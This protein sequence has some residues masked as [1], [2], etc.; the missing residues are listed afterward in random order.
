MFDDQAKN[1]LAQLLSAPT[2]ELNKALLT[3]EAAVRKAQKYG[4]AAQG[5]LWWMERELTEMKKYKPRGGVN[6]ANFQ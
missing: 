6:K 3:A 2:T 1:E 4:G 5:D